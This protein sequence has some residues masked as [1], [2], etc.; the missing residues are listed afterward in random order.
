MN[1]FYEQFRLGAG[2]PK[3]LGALRHHDIVSVEYK[4]TGTLALSTLMAI[5]E[6]DITT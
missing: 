4:R 1:V 5:Y 6:L 3:L 2:I